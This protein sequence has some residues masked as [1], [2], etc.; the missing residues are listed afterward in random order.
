MAQSHM[1]AWAGVKPAW[2]VEWA[3]MPQLLAV[4]ARGSGLHQ[5]LG[6]RVAMH[7]PD[8]TA[9]RGTRV[10]VLVLLA[11]CPSCTWVFFHRLF[12]A[13]MGS[14]GGQRI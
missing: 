11:V 5:A 4:I 2:E 12:P 1:A 6:G 14:A 10:V 9:T 8:E 7:L 13:P 3:L